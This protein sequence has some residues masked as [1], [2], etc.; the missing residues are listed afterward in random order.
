MTGGL[1]TS[2]LKIPPPPA[3]GSIVGEIEKIRFDT[4]ESVLNL[5]KAKAEKEINKCTSQ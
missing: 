2:Q 4:E 5:A 3:Y 1:S